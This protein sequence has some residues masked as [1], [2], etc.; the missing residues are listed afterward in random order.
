MTYKMYVMTF[1]VAHFG[2]DKLDSSQLSFTADR[3]F[4]A[5]CQEALKMGKLEEFLSLAEQDDFVL[6]DA[7]PY[8]GEAYLPKPIEY[9]KREHIPAVKNVKTLRRQA[10]LSKNYSISLCQSLSNFY[11][12][13][14][15]KM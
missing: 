8:I 2:K 7:F 4:S 1:Q 15:L 11:Q 6:T 10:K 14:Y 5:L 12:V 3:L 9:P 13:S